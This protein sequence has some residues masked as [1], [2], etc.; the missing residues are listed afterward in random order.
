MKRLILALGVVALLIPARVAQAEPD[1]SGLKP[2]SPETNFMS[3]LGFVR[4]RVLVETGV[5]TS[6]EIQCGYVTAAGKPTGPVG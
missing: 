3:F 6:R 1:I 4:Y 2:F 5:W